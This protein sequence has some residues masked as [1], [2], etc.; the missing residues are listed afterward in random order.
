MLPLLLF[1]QQ[2]LLYLSIFLTTG[3]PG[4]YPGAAA[5]G[6]QQ[7]QQQQ[8]PAQTTYSNGFV[9]P[10]SLQLLPLYAMSLQKSLVLRGGSDVRVDERAYFQLCLLNMD[11]QESK[12]FI[13]P[14]MFSI[15]VSADRYYSR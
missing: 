10:S 15:Q 14:R 13:Y 5:Y 4:Q 7:Q 11:I 1:L 2:L 6:Y 9:L 8:S 12:N 3:M